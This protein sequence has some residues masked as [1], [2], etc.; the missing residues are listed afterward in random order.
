MS[1]RPLDAKVEIS[2]TEEYES[3]IKSDSED[4]VKLDSINYS[5]S[6]L[7]FHPKRKSEN[8]INNKNGK[9]NKKYEKKISDLLNQI[10]LLNHELKMTEK[11]K[12]S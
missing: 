5:D 11:K 4:S 3:H 1:N 10:E 8:K 6:S 2:K 9:I 12:N 7:D